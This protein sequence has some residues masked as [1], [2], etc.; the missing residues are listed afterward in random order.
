MLFMSFPFI[1]TSH[2]AVITLTGFAV[3]VVAIIALVVWVAALQRRI[4]R[5]LGGNAESIE[6]GLKHVQQRLDAAERFQKESTKY[7][8]AIEVR[9][10]RSLQTS[11][12]VRF[13]P[14]KGTGAGGNQSFATAFVNENGDGVV[15]S[16]LYSR[17]RV[18]VFS[19]PVK[20]FKPVYEL[21]EEEAAVVRQAEAALK[22]KPQD[23]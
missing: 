9:V 21:S 18:S 1:D 17:E 13:N 15:L 11:D 22:Q 10:K 14:F 19:K 20:E 16:S 23:I 12:T 6:E 5:L 2:I 3:A 8:R 7:L 4:S